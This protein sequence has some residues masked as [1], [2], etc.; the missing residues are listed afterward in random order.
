MA[1][2]IMYGKTINWQIT[3]QRDYTG[4]KGAVPY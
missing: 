4:S 1:C 3:M 2:N